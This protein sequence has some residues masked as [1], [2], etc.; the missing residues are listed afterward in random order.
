VHITARADGF[1]QL[2]EDYDLREQP[3]EQRLDLYLRPLN[4]ISIRLVNPDGSDLTDYAVADRGLIRPLC[5]AIVATQDE[6]GTS[7][8]LVKEASTT[9]YERGTIIATF[10][11]QRSTGPVDYRGIYKLADPLPVYVSACRSTAVLATQRVTLAGSEVVLTIPPQA[12]QATSGALHFRVADALSG[13]PLDSARASIMPN[14]SPRGIRSRMPHSNRE[15]DDLAAVGADVRLDGLEPGVYVLDL[16]AL[17]HERVCEYIAVQPGGVTDLGTYRLMSNTT[18]DGVVS[19]A[20]G[21]PR[22]G[23]RVEALPFDGDAAARTGS[24]HDCTSDASGHFELQRMGRG[25][26]LV[27]AGYGIEAGSIEVD[28]SSGSAHDVALKLTRG[29]PVTLRTA[30]GDGAWSVISIFDERHFLVA[31]KTFVDDQWVVPLGPGAYSYEAE[32]V[33]SPRLARGTFVVE[34]TPVE[35]QVTK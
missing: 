13:A 21:R 15:V 19:D 24:R 23:A 28:T 12:L 20:S 22:R 7:I 34:A 2:E 31:E 6:P 4:S 35:V 18:I 16:A 1:E 17:D 25:K 8:P 32:A 29:T 30:S 10:G 26:Y 27:R 3:S 9:R 5:I 14:R 11:A 33:G